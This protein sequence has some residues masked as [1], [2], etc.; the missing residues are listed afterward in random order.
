MITA[1][2]ARQIAFDKVNTTYEECF[3]NFMEAILECIEEDAKKGKLDIHLAYNYMVDKYFKNIKSDDLYKTL[4]EIVKERFAKLGF[5]VS[6]MTTN[7]SRD[8]TLTISW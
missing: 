3:D 8:I 7:I 5:N 4:S 6:F 2:E 1:N